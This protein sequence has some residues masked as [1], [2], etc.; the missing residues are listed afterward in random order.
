MIPVKQAIGPKSFALKV[1][2][3]GKT[4]IAELVGEKPKR[5]AGKAFSKKAERRDEIPPSAFPTY[6]TD[7]IEDLMT[8]YNQTCAYSCFRIHPITGAASVDHMAP[9]SRRWDKI[10][11]WDNYRLACSRM[12]ARKNNFEDLVLTESGREEQ[13]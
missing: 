3:P 9:K 10:Y 2:N 4:A 5:T 6:W 12:N 11:E 8:A 13:E 1:R 7:C